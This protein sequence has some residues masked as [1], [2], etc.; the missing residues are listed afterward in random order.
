MMKQQRG[1]S[2]LTIAVFLLLALITLSSNNNQGASFFVSAQGEDKDDKDDAEEDDKDDVDDDDDDVDDVEDEPVVI[3]A[4][5]D[6]DMMSNNS[7]MDTDDEGC[8][9]DADNMIS[10]TDPSM[11]SMCMCDMDGELEC[12][13]TDTD[14]EPPKKDED[15]GMDV[16]TDV[17]TGAPVAAP[18]ATPVIVSPTPAS[19]TTEATG[20]PAVSGG[21]AAK[22]G[23][24]AVVAVAIS[25]FAGLVALN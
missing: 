8:S 14:T 4:P 12:D 6:D 2:I 24:V 17:M 5:V 15:P 20:V 23:A 16:P 21:S 19:T 10:C 1:V 22:T 11:E 7:T 9:C 3:S 18:V 25:A 13:E